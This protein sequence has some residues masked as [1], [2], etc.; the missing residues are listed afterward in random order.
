MGLFTKIFNKVILRFFQAYT[1]E[2]H[3]KGLNMRF[4]FFPDGHGDLLGRGH[5]AFHEIYLD[6]D[7]FMIKLINN[8]LPDDPAEDF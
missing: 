8:M 4:Q 6:I 2:F 1:V 3:I 5:S 7:V